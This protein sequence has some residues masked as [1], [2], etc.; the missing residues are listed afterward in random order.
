[1]MS[2]LAMLGMIGVTLAGA[3]GATGSDGADTIEVSEET[4][5]DAKKKL[6]VVEVRGILVRGRAGVGRGA[7]ATGF[8][9]R[10]LDRAL[11]DEQVAG[12][13]LHLDTPG[14]SVTDADLLHERIKR[15]RENGK[16]VLV[17]M[18]DLCASGGYYAAVAANEVWAL[19]TTIT[20]SIGVI[21]QSLNVH[22]LLE[23]YGVEDVSI[24]SGANKALL[25]PTRPMSA[26]HRRLLQEVV[27]HLY[28]RFVDLVAAGRGLELD[29]VEQLADG[30]IFTAEQALE[31]KL[32]DGIGY[33][34]KALSK[35]K[36]I[37]EGGPFNVVRYSRRPSMWSLLTASRAEPPGP[38][39]ALVEHISA[40][41]RAMYLYAPLA[42]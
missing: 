40:A 6:A 34:K 29:T 17:H 41:P 32:V 42:R 7:G 19:P 39:A 13:L 8:A 5:P 33:R 28:G 4:H 11:E 31:A 27:D 12:V 35:L 10:M 1:M 3:V 22:Q 30:R 26:E 23:R 9:L 20:G 24:T 2:G 14:G 15:L 16:A 25:S 36:Q 38:A 37:S 21:I 18:G